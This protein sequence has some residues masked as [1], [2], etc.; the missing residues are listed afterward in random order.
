MLGRMVTNAFVNGLG[1]FYN[2]AWSAKQ[3]GQ[4]FTPNW[5]AIGASAGAGLLGG[6]LGNGVA[7]EVGPLFQGG[8]SGWGG[9]ISSGFAQGPVNGAGSIWAN[10]MDALNTTGPPG[11]PPP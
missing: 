7:G 5:T 2:E 4:P 3:K 11:S 10:L 9:N 8:S 6:E 1:E